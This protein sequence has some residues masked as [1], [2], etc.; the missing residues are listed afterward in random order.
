MRRGR[1]GLHYAA[2]HVSDQ[3]IRL[4]PGEPITYHS[5]TLRVAGR[6][7]DYTHSL[8][9]QRSNSTAILLFLPL[10]VLAAKEFGHGRSRSILSDARV[11]IIL[12]PFQQYL[13]L[14]GMNVGIGLI[15]FEAPPSGMMYPLFYVSV[16]EQTKTAAGYGV[17]YVRL[18]GKLPGVYGL[19]GTRC[20]MH[21]RGWRYLPQVGRSLRGQVYSAFFF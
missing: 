8:M 7:R 4:T 16:H 11:Y 19:G 12:P 5:Q 21:I 3:I 20:E 14:L 17:G 9:P 13:N 15:G 18:L 10:F 1:R 6:E 2:T